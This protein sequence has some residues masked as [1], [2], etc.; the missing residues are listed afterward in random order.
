LHLCW[1]QSGLWS[2]Y[3]CFSVGRITGVYHHAQFFKKN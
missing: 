2:S 3:L 1:S